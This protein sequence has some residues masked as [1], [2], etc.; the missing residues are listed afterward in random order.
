MHDFHL[1]NKIVKLAREYAEKNKLKKINGIFIELGDIIEHDEL[2]NPDNLR[3]NIKLL[4]P[5]IKTIKIK[6]IK[7][8][9]WK[10]VSIEG[11]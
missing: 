7:G 3:Y 11:V 9:K 10:L 1:A 4:M 2:I 6:Q 8:D 5:S